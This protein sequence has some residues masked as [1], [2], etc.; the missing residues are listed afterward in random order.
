MKINLTH[1]NLF[2]LFLKTSMRH[3]HF[4]NKIDPTQI[5]KLVNKTLKLSQHKALNSVKNLKYLKTKRFTFKIYSTQN[6][7]IH[8]LYKIKLNESK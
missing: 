7:P 6:T 3:R 4:I 8:Y 2:K 1:L 5:Y